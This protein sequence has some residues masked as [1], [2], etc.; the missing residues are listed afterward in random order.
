MSI[1]ILEKRSSHADPLDA[2]EAVAGLLELEAERVDDG[3]LHVALPG[4]WRDSGVWFTWRPE[5]STIQMGA[6]LDIKAPDNR[7]AEAATLVTMIN[8]RLWLGHFDLWAEDKS[9]VYRNAMILPEESGLEAN[10]AQLLLRGTSEAIDRFFPAFNYFV[11]GGK[12]P[13]DAIEAA[14]FDTVGSA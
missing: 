10:Q 1:Q 7:C 8:E 14:I 6:P 2:L 12:S 9:F 4:A 5:L 11:W 3:E 13:A